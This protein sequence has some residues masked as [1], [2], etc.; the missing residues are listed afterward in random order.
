MPMQLEE[1]IAER[2]AG[3]SYEGIDTATLHVLK[4]NLL[5]SYASICGSLKDNTMLVK[6]DRLA[7]DRASS[8]D[9]G[10]W[11]IGR[12]ATCP[13]AFF[14]NAVLARRSDLLNT[15]V[16]PNGM[17]VA[18]P[19][20]NVALVLTLADWLGM[21]GRAALT[22][23]YTAFQLSAAFATYYDPESAGYDH[24]AAAT[25]Y[26]AL[27]IAHALGMSRDQ[28]VPVQRIAGSLGLDVN[29]RPPS[30]R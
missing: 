25:F 21:D 18:H 19:S 1:Q 29:H 11:G 15:Y 5:D 30:A 12:K 4:R 3:M 13:D 17:G 27:T 6:F 24:D 28:L 23:M 22:S 8:N 2:V 20:D 16:S 7:A 9:V 10:V 26:T 14:M